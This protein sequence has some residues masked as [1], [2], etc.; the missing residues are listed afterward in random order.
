MLAELA[1]Y[2][3][4]VDLVRALID[5]APDGVSRAFAWGW[6]THVLA[7]AWIHPLVNRGVGRKLGRGGPAGLSYAEDPVHHVR[8]ELGLDAYYARHIDVPGRLGPAPFRGLVATRFIADAY[9]ET[10]GIRVDR[11]RLFA[12]IRNA[13]RLVPWM[14]SCERLIAPAM[15]RGATTIRGR[16]RAR[17][18]LMACR[19]ASWLLPRRSV[20][21][22]LLRPDLPPDRLIAEVD[23]VLDRFA[24]RFV[25]LSK[26]GLAELPQYNLDTGLEEGEWPEYPLSRASLRTLER[27]RGEVPALSGRGRR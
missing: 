12:S 7:D 21:Y 27:L 25:R 14:L 6:A 2:L 5:R 10:Y 13:A 18:V 3:K 1:H 22:G 4:P 17:L 26:Q 19:V 15:C 8:V 9:D 24:G 20:A 16:T 23:P 11:R